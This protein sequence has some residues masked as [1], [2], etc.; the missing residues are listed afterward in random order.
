MRLPRALAATVVTAASIGMTAA[1]VGVATAVANDA[2]TPAVT[3]TY[4]CQM[5]DDTPAEGGEPTDVPGS[6]FQA[7]E[8]IWRYWNSG[9]TPIQSWKSGVGGSG[10]HEGGALQPGFDRFAGESAGVTFRTTSGP[11]DGVSVTSD[12]ENTSRG[13]AS[14][15]GKICELIEP[16]PTPTPT[17]T[18]TPTE[19][20]T[21]TPEATEEPV[22]TDVPAGR[23]GSGDGVTSTQLA[24]LAAL[25]VVGVVGATAATRA[26]RQES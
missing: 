17:P 20:P 5:P 24:G 16:T 8:H 9:D 18:E 6:T 4:M 21:G 26:R 7:G 10:L 15:S 11:V 1:S 14:T 12:P 19:T 25:T 23:P 13:T 22:P 3:V 2:P